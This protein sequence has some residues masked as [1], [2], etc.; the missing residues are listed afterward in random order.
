MNFFTRLRVSSAL[1]VLP[2]SLV[3]VVFYYGK[4]GSSPGGVDYAPTLVSEALGTM[5]SF[6]YAVVS[7]LGVWE[8]GKL[9]QNGLWS[10]GAGR[11]RFHI[12]ALTLVPAILLAWLMLLSPVVLLLC[13]RR[14]LPDPGSLLPLGMAMLLCIAHASIGF[15][16]GL[17]LPHLIAAP[18]MVVLV[19]IVVAF[20]WTVEPNWVRHLFGQYPTTLMFGERATVHSL[21]PHILL[22]GGIAASMWLLWLPLSRSSIRVTLACLAALGAVGGSWAMVH[23]WTFNPP[24]LTGAAPVE[25]AGRSPRVCM[26]RVTASR[27]PEVRDQMTSVLDDFRAAGVTRRPALISDTLNDGRFSVRSTARTWHVPLT[28]IADKGN[29]RY[30]FALSAVRFPCRRPD[31]FTGAVVQAWVARVT[32]EGA[33]YRKTTKPQQGVEAEVARVAAMSVPEQAKWFR[34]SL[35]EGCER[36]A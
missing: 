29:S 10:V 31:P 26:P 28:V 19:W 13:E 9:R 22:T 21:M 4:N 14:V 1:R 24:L 35:V 11:S 25:C 20:S 7:G 12:A 30:Q 17:R 8:G 27:L 18:L 2:F 32:D 23:T 6:A 33:A 5:Y 15:G 3:L 36:G 16:I 34:N